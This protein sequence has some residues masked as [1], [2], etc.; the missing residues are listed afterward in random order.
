MVP[1]DW[2]PI[3]QTSNALRKVKVAKRHKEYF[4][5]DAVKFN[6]IALLYLLVSPWLLN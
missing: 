3:T 6:R 2:T 1:S 5:I 4:L